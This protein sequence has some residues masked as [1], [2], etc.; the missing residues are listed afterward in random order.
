MILVLSNKKYFTK[1]V[2]GTQTNKHFNG[3]KLVYF[4]YDKLEDI[5]IDII[6]LCVELYIIGGENMF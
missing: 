4:D 5:I 1:E 6:L 3:K 2:Y